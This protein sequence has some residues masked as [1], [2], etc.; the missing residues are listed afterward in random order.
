MASRG[1]HA[2]SLRPKEKKKMNN[3]VFKSAIANTLSPSIAS[4]K[5]IGIRYRSALNLAA[6]M[7]V[8]E[9]TAH[10]SSIR[11]ESI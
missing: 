8:K 1:F 11:K 5:A 3:P 2:K 6:L 7:A 9:T 4:L 10:F